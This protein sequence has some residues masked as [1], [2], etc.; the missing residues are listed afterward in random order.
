M[1]LYVHSRNPAEALGL[2]V[3]TVYVTY[4]LSSAPMMHGIPGKKVATISISI[5]LKP[6]CYTDSHQLIL[7]Y[8]CLHFK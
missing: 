1:T 4:R 5:K 7:G 6:I 2:N 8:F 3:F